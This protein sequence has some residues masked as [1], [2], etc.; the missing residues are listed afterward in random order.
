MV[1]SVNTDGTGFAILH[2]FAGYPSDGANTYY[3]LVL[4][5]NTLY[6]TTGNGGSGDNG[7]VFALNTNGTSYTILHNFA[8][9]EPDAANNSEGAL[10]TGGLVLSGNTLYGTANDGGSSGRG[11]VFSL[12]TNGTGFTTV[13]NFAGTG[14]SYPF[15]DLTLSG[16][17]LYGTSHDA[18]FAVNTDGT[19]FTSLYTFTG[20]STNSLGIYTNSAGLEPY[21]GLIL[22]GKIL[23]GATEYGGG[24]DNGTVFALSA[25]LV[26][27]TANPFTGVAPLTVNFSSSGVDN[28]G[29]AITNRNWGFGDGFTSI[30]Q[31]PSHTYIAP[32]NFSVNFL[33]TNN[34]GVLIS[35]TPLFITVSPPTVQYTANPTN[36]PVPLTVQFNS[37]GVDTGGS[38]ISR[39]N[40]TFGDGSTSTAQNASHIYTSAG[41]GTFYPSLIAT[42]ILGLTVIASGPA[43]STPFDSGLVVNGG[44]ETGDFS[45]WTPSGDTSYTFVDNGS[46]SGIAPYPGS[47]LTALGTIGSRGYLSQTLATTVGTTYLLSC[48]LDSPDGLTPNE[49]LVSWDGNILFDQTDLSAIGWT[50]LQFVVT[51][52][53][54]STVLQ[55]GFLDDDTYLGLDDISVVPSQES[56]SAPQLT[57]IPSGANVILSWPTNAA[58]LTF[59]LQSTT[60]LVSPAMW[61]AVSPVFVLENGQNVV[62]NAISGARRFYRLSQ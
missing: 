10:P 32:G 9:F 25:N 60:N 23:Y 57:I 2:H 37:P 13:H 31:N 38:A 43:I 11:T 21:G 41:G 48:R 56:V 18:V 50:N 61:A 4:S 12:N 58:G 14:G 7:T 35:E 54:T 1:F 51:A 5:G 3:G 17:T 36:G 8:P 6:G 59:T 34:N 55:F 27:I 39:W 45:G 40:W 28:F 20:T 47:Y 15:A 16:N 19:G 42:N 33:A 30:I 26:P 22:S 24:A 29:N 46:Q 62:T 52:A 44:F 49:F 53:E